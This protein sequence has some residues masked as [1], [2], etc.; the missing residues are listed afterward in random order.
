MP[1]R[2]PIIITGASGFV[3]SNLLRRIIEKMPPKKVHV[4]LRKKSNIW[5]IAD[6]LKKVQVH[7]ADLRSREE[8]DR[9]MRLVK[10]KIVFH[11]A[12]HGAYPYQQHDENEIFETN[13]LGTFN[14]M[15]SASAAGCRAFINTGSSSEYGINQ[16]PMSERDA[17]RPVTAYGVSKAF[18]TL[19][20]KY[21][22][23]SRKAPITTLRLFG[24]YGFYEPRGRL[25][26]NI[27]LSLLNGEKLML[28]KPWFKRDFIFIDDVVDVY[29]LAAKKS[30]SGLVLNIGSGKQASIKE[31]YSSLLGIIKVP[32]KP[33][34]NK[35]RADARDI[36]RR[37]A[38][39]A[40]AKK[41]L[42]WKP[43]TGLDDGL[44]QT[45]NWF[46][47]NLFLYDKQ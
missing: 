2:T 41:Y 1:L 39:I 14:L 16:K 31:V 12:A 9:I 7:A 25:I 24:V 38:D 30:S 23:L 26:P 3:G 20:G 47:K 15:S 13:V 33:L 35:S 42:G 36:N 22:A 5:R 34:W 27:I 40:L 32:A 8:T 6:V 18:A 37:I 43:K 46:K 19:W 4:L 28:N 44:R 29:I 45:V 21:L 10:P 11:L 17:L